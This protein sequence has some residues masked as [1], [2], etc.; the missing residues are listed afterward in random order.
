MQVIGA[1]LGRTGTYSLKAALNQ[2]GLGPCHHMEEVIR[3]LP[4]HVPLWQAALDDKP[5]WAAIYEGYDSAV[6]WPTASFFREL[7]AVYPK[8]KFILS[9][10]TPE[11]WA[12]S[13]GQTIYAVLAMRD[14][15]PPERREWL[16]MVVAV[17]AK[18]GFPPGLDRDG[19]INGF[20]AHDRAVRAAIPADRL[21][22][23]DVKQGWGPL[24][25]FVGKPAPADPFPRTNDREQFFELLKGEGATAPP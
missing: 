23:F 8:A 15:A 17:V 3:N 5:D 24:C 19:L 25:D 10:R 6:D 21:L 7:A 12:D 11:S 20:L 1:G 22:V 18:A 14:K 9:T 4:R 16:E 13:F 2:L